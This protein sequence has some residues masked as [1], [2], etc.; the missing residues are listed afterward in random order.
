MV[1]NYWLHFFILPFFRYR[2]I[3][4]INFPPSQNPSITMCKHEEKYCPR[5]KS[6]FECKVGDIT[7]CQCFGIGL[8]PEEKKFLE[9]RY[10][11]CLCRN[12]LLEL[13]PLTP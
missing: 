8:N 2:K 10:E 1:L 11:D 9:E 3:Y 7:Q 5:C 13:N 4:S 12:C 6:A